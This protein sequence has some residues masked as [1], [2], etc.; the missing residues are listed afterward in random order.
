MNLNDFGPNTRALV[1]GKSPAELLEMARTEGSEVPDEMLENISGGAW[2]DKPM[3][4]QCPNGKHAL[5]KVGF[6]PSGA[7]MIVF[8]KCTKCGFETD[9]SGVGNNT[10]L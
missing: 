9:D 7:G 8:Y 10:V 1:E 3:P 2:D 4:N 5:K 6:S